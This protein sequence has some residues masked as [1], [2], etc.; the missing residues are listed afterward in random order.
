M[1]FFSPKKKKIVLIT[2]FLIIT[3][4]AVYLN[5][6]YAHIY[7]KIGVAG[8]KFPE[9]GEL[10]M[11]NDGLTTDKNI[12]YTAL[13][14]SLTAGV[15]TDS[16]EETLPYLLAQDL[17]QDD[18]RVI[19]SNLA[20]P[21]ARTS[22]IIGI[23]LSKAIEDRPD[24]VTLLIGVNDIHNH[25]SAAQ[26][27]KNYEEILIRLSK[28]TK[29]TIYAVN[30]PFIGGSDIMLPPYQYFFDS[31]VKEFNE[32]IKELANQ[33]AVQ[34]IDLY[35]P[36]VNLFKKSG[37]HYSRDSFHPSAAGYKIWAD[38]IYAGINK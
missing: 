38:I 12:I 25:V 32:I 17:G 8:L 35:S 29:A 33:Y 26:F 16:P 9:Q 7:T 18:K 21:G 20:V 31:R 30:I 19:L 28:E 3:V 10:Y 6:S 11:I 13:G 5:R 15:G 36:S 24:V 14:D 4:I 23:F 2:I 1:I 27:R 34:Y 37:A 22:D